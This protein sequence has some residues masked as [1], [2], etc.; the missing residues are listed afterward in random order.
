MKKFLMLLGLCI[1]AL[2][3]WAEV[4]VISVTDEDKHSKKE[5][6]Y[7][8]F[9]YFITSDG[10]TTSKCQATRISNRWFVTAA[11]CVKTLCAKSCTLHMDLLDTPVSVFAQG[12]HTAKKP[13]VFIHPAYFSTQEIGKD[14]A[15]IRLDINRADKVYYRRPTKQNE[16]MQT[17]SLQT[18]EAW[19][20]KHRR[21]NSQ[22]RHV[23][24]PQ[25]PPI[26][27]F[28][29]G[30]YVL[31]RKVS[32][33]S[34]FDGKRQVKPDPHAV[35]Y[36]KELGYAYTNDFG[37]RKGMSGSGVMTNTGELIGI[38]SA[39]LGADCPFF[40]YNEPMMATGIGD[41]LAPISLSLAGKALYLVK[42]AVHVATAQAYAG[43]TPQ[44]VV[45]SL[46]DDLAAPVASWH[47]N[48]K[49]DFEPSVFKAHPS[50][51][52]IKRK[53]VDAGALY[54]AMSG[55]GASIFGIFDSANMAEQLLGTIPCERDFV[56][57]L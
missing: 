26:A 19:L 20:A 45:R 4:S 29:N 12:T 57:N 53:I 43:V 47:R 15:L 54:A 1:A 10:Q 44:P 46:A 17:L 30:N 31:D 8:T 27:V 25:I 18:F 22:Y 36:V 21:A 55:S 38:I 49:N 6:F 42:P 28:D 5:D 3:V 11:H 52:A 39:T 34:I 37:I 51:A 56:I 24:S 32:V 40:V 23:L 41:R 14:V 33:I 9:E 7:H 35:Y 48:V 13:S 50:L 2:A 16:N